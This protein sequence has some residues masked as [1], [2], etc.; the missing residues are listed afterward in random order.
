MMKKFLLK[1]ITN[2]E[3][4]QIYIGKTRLYGDFEIH[5]HDFSEMF[6]VLSGSAIHIIDNEYY[7]VN[8]GD[9]YVINGDISH[10][11]RSPEDFEICNIMYRPET[12]FGNYGSLRRLPGFQALFVFEPYYRYEHKFKSRLTLDSQSKKKAESLIDEMIFEYD[13]K[14]EGYEVIFQAL[15]IELIVL[16]SRQYMHISEKYPQSIFNLSNT[17]AYIER[18]FSKGITLEKLASM[19]FMSKRH[20]GRVFRNNY[21]ITPYKYIINLRITHA[22][23]LLAD[24]SMSVSEIALNSGFSD[25]NYFSRCFKNVKGMSPKKYR[26]I[27][28]FSK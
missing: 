6:I 21:N 7:T 10:G 26:M 20:F 13:K 12:M 3:K 25:I 9:I 23:S 27:N 22:C 18:N 17:I 28:H 15:F 14:E 8:E 16:L 1:N 11:F 4:E 2:D 24:S 5:T 19:A